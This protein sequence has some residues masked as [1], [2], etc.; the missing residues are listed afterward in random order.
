MNNSNPGGC[1]FEPEP[2][3]YCTRVLMELYGLTVLL[4]SWDS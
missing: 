4:D 2:M 3:D 1:L